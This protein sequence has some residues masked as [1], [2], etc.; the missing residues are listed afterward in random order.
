MA[1][2]VAQMDP[3]IIRLVGR[4]CNDNILHYLHTTANSFMDGL[5]TPLPA[6]NK[7][8]LLSLSTT[9]LYKEVG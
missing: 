6:A 1:I 5:V 3:E 8:V 9:V 2:L 4:W 7:C